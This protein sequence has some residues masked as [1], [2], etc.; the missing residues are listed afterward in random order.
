MLVRRHERP[1]RQADRCGGYAGDH[2]QVY[3][4]NAVS[5]VNIMDTMDTMDTVDIMDT[6]NTVNAGSDVAVLSK[7]SFVFLEKGYFLY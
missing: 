2:R 1:Y 5:I 6:V 7:I 4:V 3:T